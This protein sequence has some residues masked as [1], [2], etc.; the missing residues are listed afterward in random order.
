[1][2]FRLR[3]GQFQALIVAICIL[4]I[5]TPSSAYG[6]ALSDQSVREAYFL[7][8]SRNGQTEDVLGQYVHHFPVPR[9]GPNITEIRLDTPFTQVVECAEETLEYTAE[10]AEQEFFGKSLPLRISAKTYFTP[11]YTAILRSGPD[12]VVP[13]SEDLW[14]NF[15]VRFTQHQNVIPTQATSGR[16]IFASSQKGTR[17][18]IGAEIYA[19]YSTQRIS[20]DIAKI[21]IV[22]PDGPAVATTFDLSKL[23]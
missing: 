10:D 17:R 1:M 20:S 16:P 19:E 7:G 4:G 15:K 13:R 11:S 23:R 22:G 3:F 8:R 18:I 6:S 21:E 12:G 2:I 14:K 5:A 9:S